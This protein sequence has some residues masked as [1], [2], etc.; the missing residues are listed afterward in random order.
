MRYDLA[1]T[2]ALMEKLG[3]T[4]MYIPALLGGLCGLRRGE[5]VALRW[6]DVNRRFFLCGAV[7]FR[8]KALAF[9][10]KN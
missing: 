8:L 2:A 5:I 6:G 4:R 9:S 1:Q 3:T 7:L 10:H